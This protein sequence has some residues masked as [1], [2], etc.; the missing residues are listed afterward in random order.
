MPSGDVSLRQKKVSELLRRAVS[1]FITKNPFFISSYRV[2]A[3][4]R[5]TVSKDLMICDLFLNYLKS[6]SNNG[7]VDENLEINTEIMIKL[8][9]H[10][11][12]TCKL[13]R[14]PEINIYLTD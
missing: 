6:E 4:S 1:D 10:I 5:A 7:I 9:K 11:A 14:I 8:K 3:C 2:F 12:E 13:R